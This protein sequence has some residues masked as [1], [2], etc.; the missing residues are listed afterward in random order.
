MSRA[1]IFIT[2][3]SSPLGRQVIASVLIF[4]TVEFRSGDRSEVAENHVVP[5]YCTQRICRPIEDQA[6]DET[7]LNRPREDWCDGI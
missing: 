4:L 5:N 2:R 7:T 1:A 3:V 6:A